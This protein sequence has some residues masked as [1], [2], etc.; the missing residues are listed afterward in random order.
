MDAFKSRAESNK[1]LADEFLLDARNDSG[2]IEVT[3]TGLNTR[4][5]T[6]KDQKAL[7]SMMDYFT[8]TFEFEAKEIFI[9][10][11]FGYEITLPHIIID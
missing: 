7:Q 6:S 4:N 3:F 9:D 1:D 2:G 10:N 5:I 11:G 8:G